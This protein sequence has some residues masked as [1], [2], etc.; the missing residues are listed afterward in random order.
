MKKIVLITGANGMLAKHLEKV[1]EKEYSVRFLTR[2]KRKDNDYLWD[3]KK[4]YIEKGALIDVH[5]IIHLAG[6]SI[7]KKRWTL[8]RKES[9]LT[10]RVDSAKLILNELQKHQ[11]KI[12]SFI[13]ASAVGYYGAVTS[14]IIFNEES[15]N[16]TDFVSEVCK[17]WENIAD[18]FK[19]RNITK[20]L[21]IVRIGIIL[22]SNNGAINKMIN[23][24]RYGMG[25]VIGSGKQY[26]PWI[27]IHDL[28]QIFKFLLLNKNVAG[29]FNAV[30]PEHTTNLELTYKIAKSL[31]RKLILPKIPKFAIQL[32]MGE[33]ATI[34]LEGSRVSSNKIISEGF[35]FKYPNLNKA[36]ENL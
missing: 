24:I 15:P 20:R 13:S 16:G 19:N 3:I 27:H 30:S 31:N 8:K 1:L 6:S 21:A 9:I 5:S 23:L 35:S 26:V 22:S 28:S 11:L 36:L 2:N 4:S 7:V 14:D 34:L 25:A 12:D 10:S 32:L 18:E 17:E 29:T 33:M